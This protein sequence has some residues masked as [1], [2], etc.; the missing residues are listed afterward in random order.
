M[1]G[2]AESRRRGRGLVLVFVA[3]EEGRVRRL[4]LEEVVVVWL[5]WGFR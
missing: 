2:W 3:C 1:N 5:V 4:F